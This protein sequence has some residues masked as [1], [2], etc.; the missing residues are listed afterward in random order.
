M[1]GERLSKG[2]GEADCCLAAREHSR[3]ILR[4]RAEDLRRKA[5][6]LDVLA[7]HVTNMSGDAEAAVWNL[8][9]QAKL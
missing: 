9:M 6:E 8:L 5:T 3:D 7:N 1:F 2:G 4:R